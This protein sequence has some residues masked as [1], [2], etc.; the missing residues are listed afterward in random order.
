LQDGK[1]KSFEIDGQEFEELRYIKLLH[2]ESV[3][4]KRYFQKLW[5]VAEL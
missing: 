1:K 5:I 3:S 4:G 2:N